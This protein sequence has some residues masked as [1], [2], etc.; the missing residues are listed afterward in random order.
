MTMGL[1]EALAMG[2]GM[3]DRTPEY[4]ELTEQSIRKDP[5][6]V[7][8]DR[9]FNPDEM[10][11]RYAALAESEGFPVRGGPFRLARVQMGRDLTDAMDG[12]GFGYGESGD[13]FQGGPSSIFLNLLGIRPMG[14]NQ[15]NPQGVGMPLRAPMETFNV[16]PPAF[17]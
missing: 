10:A 14:F 11:D 12:G 3:K 1:L 6:G 15:R 13:T 8:R 7:Y 16:L 5:L 9:G 4:Y 17:R 2:F